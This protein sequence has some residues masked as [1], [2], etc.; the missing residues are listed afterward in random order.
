[1]TIWDYLTKE[2]LP[3]NIRK[4]DDGLTT[5]F[6]PNPKHKIGGTKLS[7]W[8]MEL[9]GTKTFC[10]ETAVIKLSDDVI[11][12]M[13]KSQIRLPKGGLKKRIFR[14]QEDRTI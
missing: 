7:M 11:D 4:Y 3:D 9:P 12:R 13:K 6:V 14:K 2:M 1:M 10:N 8:D 5:L